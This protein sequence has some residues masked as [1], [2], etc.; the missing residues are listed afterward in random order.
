MT[1]GMGDTPTPLSA[2]D[3]RDLA[4]FGCFTPGDVDPSGACAAGRAASSY[5]LAAG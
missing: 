1:A 4:R 3:V 5:L 2:V